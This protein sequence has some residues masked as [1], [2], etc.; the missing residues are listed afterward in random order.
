MKKKTLCPSLVSL[1]FFFFFFQLL[2]SRQYLFE[3]KSAL[4]WHSVGTCLVRTK[5]PIIF[6]TAIFLWGQ[7][8]DL[9]FV[10]KII[11]LRTKIFGSTNYFFIKAGCEEGSIK[12]SRQRH[13]PWHKLTSKPAGS[14]GQRQPGKTPLTEDIL[15]TGCRTIT[16][17]GNSSFQQKL[18]NR[19]ILQHGWFTLRGRFLRPPASDLSSD[20]DEPG[21]MPWSHQL[22]VC[23]FLAA[24]SCHQSHPITVTRPSLGIPIT[25]QC[26][27][28]SR[29]HR[30][31]S[32]IQII[33]LRNC[34]SR[35]IRSRIPCKFFFLHFLS[36][37][38][39]PYRCP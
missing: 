2:Q 28:Q 15:H 3:V 20:D 11:H 4:H 27:D 36:P 30:Q 12:M 14:L 16:S 18:G 5:R 35:T 19:P 8:V 37:G 21:A 9:I 33:R 34:S 13:Y 6:V 38:F 25:M 29:V 17:T 7:M 31:L 22:G 1:S 10:R 39:L 26:R 32:T 24:S 23:A